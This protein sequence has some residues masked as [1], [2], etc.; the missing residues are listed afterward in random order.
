MSFP[1]Y[2]RY[3]DSGIEWLGE[4]PEHWEIKKLKYLGEA[5]IGLTYDPSDV[6]GED[7]TLVLRSSNV[8]NGKIVFED[9]VYV[10]KII[11]EKLITKTGDILICSR[12]GSRALIGK[13]A[14]IGTES[15]GLTF[16]AFMT[17][18]RSK[19][20]NYLSYIF[21][22]SLFKFQSGSFLTSTVNQLTTSNLYTFEVP[23]PPIAEHKHIANFLD[24]E[25]TIINELIVEQQR[26]IELLKEKRQAVISHA[27]TKG[28][29]PDVPMKDSGIEW[30]GDVPEHWEVKKLGFICKKIGS[31]KTPLGG[32][33]TYI[34]SGVLF[35]RSQNVYD[36]GL[37][38]DDVVYIAEQTDSEMSFSR[39][40][41]GD[42]LLNITGASLGRTCL[43]P[44]NF[45]P[46][47]VNQHVC[48]IRLAEIN[49]RSYIAMVMK[50]NFI[51]VQID[52]IQNGAA[53]E[54][55]NFEQISRLSF[56]LPSI[57]EQAQIVS[58]LE[59]ETIKIDELTTEAEK[60]IELLKERRTALISA[61]V[62]GKIDVR[63]LVER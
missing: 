23:F 53:R 25:T 52:A 60:A 57:D 7:G 13:N 17:I 44:D 18:F 26:L 32:S 63:G 20:N 49:F 43:V 12:N 28:L 19:Y 1:R 5:L 50:S 36:E 47:N 59:C 45:V 41:P 33:T 6:V 39:V 54:G 46:A 30:L 37:I 4:I 61:A 48:I 22:S 31:G 29:N 24:R 55:L 2:E 21:N 9:N 62:T 56:G 3:K 15:T 11:P 34:D 38:I 42:I 10:R 27:V 51:K 16:G 8:Q 58:F 35:I 14:E 40:F